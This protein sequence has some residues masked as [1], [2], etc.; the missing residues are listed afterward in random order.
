MEGH[1]GEQ[2][3][4]HAEGAGDGDGARQ[5]AVRVPHLLDDEVEAVPAGE[6]EEAGV[7]GEGE[8]GGVRL[9]VGPGEVLRAAPGELHQA[10][11][12]YQQ[13]RRHLQ[14]ISPSYHPT[15]QQPT[16]A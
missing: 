13:Q 16:L 12:H 5:V 6:G 2:V 9:G 11:H 14:E 7:E 10:R 15:L 3:D 1:D 4:E 8:G